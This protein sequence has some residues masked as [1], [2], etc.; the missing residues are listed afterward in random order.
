MW[1]PAA[2]CYVTVR[3]CSMHMHASVHQQQKA[4]SQPEYVSARM[5][6]LLDQQQKAMSQPDYVS[7]CTHAFVDQQHIIAMTCKQRTAARRENDFEE[8]L[9]TV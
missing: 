1:I 9:P 4:M 8:L 3:L 7:I 2:K 5:H 6:A